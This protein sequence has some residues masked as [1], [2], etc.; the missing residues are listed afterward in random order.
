MEEDPT[1]RMTSQAA[2]EHPWLRFV[3]PYKEERLRTQSP[4]PASASIPIS[5]DVS[6]AEPGRSFA[7]EGQMSV[8][9][10]PGAYPSSQE[11]PLQRRRQVIEEAYERGLPPALPADLIANV[12]RLSAIDEA[13][14]AL[15]LAEA[16]PLKRKERES[17]DASGSAQPEAMDAEPGVP[18]TGAA[19]RGRGRGG[20]ATRGRGARPP[21]NQAGPSSEAENV[22]RSNRLQSPTKPVRA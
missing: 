7:L 8:D 11:R 9:P 15:A 16:R 20:R 22:R 19:K 6:M 18:A 21:A 1:K 10:V 13:D 4:E 5:K 14:E 2:L 17:V 12:A 3:P